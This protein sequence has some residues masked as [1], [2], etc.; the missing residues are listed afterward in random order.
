MFLERAIAGIEEIPFTDAE[1]CLPELEAVILYQE[2]IFK[3]LIGKKLASEKRRSI[4]N[5][6][7]L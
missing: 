7:S 5:E 6:K 1:F 3:K 4:G 2:G